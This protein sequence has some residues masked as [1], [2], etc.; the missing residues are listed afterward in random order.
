MLTS[1]YRLDRVTDLTAL[2]RAE[3]SEMPGLALTVQQAARLWT[4][5]PVACTQALEALVK[6]GCLRR[7]G[8]TYMGADC[9]RRSA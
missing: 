1:A 8:A 4:A 6:S 5:E 9:G 2:I 7:V 3:Y